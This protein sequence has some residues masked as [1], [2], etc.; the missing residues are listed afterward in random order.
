MTSLPRRFEYV[1]HHG[2]FPEGWFYVAGC[3]DLERARSNIPRKT[4]MGVDVVVWAD[5]N[6]R[7]CVA[8]SK[9]P[10]MGANLGPD[11]GSRISQ[12][13]LVC[14]F[15]GFQFDST[16]QYV[17]TPFAEPPRSCRLR[18]LPAREIG[19]LIFTWWRIDDREPQWSLP[20]ESPDQSGWSSLRVRTFRFPGHPQETAETSV[21]PAHLRF[22][23]GYGSVSYGSVSRWKP[24]SVDGPLLERQFDFL[25]KRRICDGPS[26][27]FDIS[28]SAFIYGLGCSPVHLVK[29][30]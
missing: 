14:P 2:P 29:P 23:R 20:A 18:V 13:R 21:D 25:S 24:L 15:H 12:G 16:G 8:E 1:R 4:W 9:C 6:G 26:L 27:P 7:G 30:V 22:V 19:G 28:A 10:H 11:C 5:D 3:H 17:A